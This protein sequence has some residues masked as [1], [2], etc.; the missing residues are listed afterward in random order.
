MTHTHKLVDHILRRNWCCHSQSS[1]TYVTIV[2]TDTTVT[3][4]T[5]SHLG[6]NF[7]LL[8]SMIHP[9]ASSNRIISI[10]CTIDPP[11]PKTH[12]HKIS[13][14][15]EMDVEAA[16]CGLTNESGIPGWM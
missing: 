8:F 2:T 12:P 4:D 7:A 6:S 15:P 9:N 16:L 5:M 11:K 10:Y 13:R 14:Y 3:T 1:S